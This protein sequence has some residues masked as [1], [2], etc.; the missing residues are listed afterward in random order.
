M[1]YSMGNMFIISHL[2]KIFLANDSGSG[3]FLADFKVHARKR[4]N[5]RQDRCIRSTFPVKALKV[6]ADFCL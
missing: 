6:L 1:Q 3:N 5:F 4:L 2:Q